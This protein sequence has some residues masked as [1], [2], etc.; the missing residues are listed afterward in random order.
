VDV[1]TTASIKLVAKAAL[2]SCFSRAYLF[3]VVQIPLMVLA[4]PV[5]WEVCGLLVG[6]GFG[7][8][9]E[10]LVVKLAKFK[11]HIP[12][13]VGTLRLISSSAAGVDIVAAVSSSLVFPW[14][15]LSIFTKSSRKAPTAK[16][17]AANGGRPNLVAS[18]IYG[19]LP[20]TATTSLS[21]LHA[22]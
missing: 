17:D 1:S 13:R 11:P 12:S 16:A 7:A 10:R 21:T 3:E 19:K 18:S 8:D 15:A 14:G 20:S 4:R 9:S 6:D 5:S 2:G 22:H